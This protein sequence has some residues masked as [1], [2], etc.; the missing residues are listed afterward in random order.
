MH[1]TTTRFQVRF[2]H[3]SLQIKQITLWPQ[4]GLIT[5][6]YKAHRGALCMRV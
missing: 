4:I 6:V 2:S 1:E 3:R 5:L